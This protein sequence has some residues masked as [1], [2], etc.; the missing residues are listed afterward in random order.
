MPCWNAR[1]HDCCLVGASPDGRLRH[2]ELAWPRRTVL[3]LGEEGDGLDDAD[4]ALCAQ[5][6]HIPMLGA[7][8]SLNVAVAAGVLLFE[9]LRVQRGAIR[10]RTPP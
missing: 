4:R 10:G 7:A 3:V 9:A 1:A 8:D 5:L 6:V 2:D